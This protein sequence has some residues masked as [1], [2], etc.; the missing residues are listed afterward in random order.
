[1]DKM[2][3]PEK[4]NQTLDNVENFILN[5]L[6][7]QHDSGNDLAMKFEELMEY[8][9]TVLPPL[10]DQ[11]IEDLVAQSLIRCSD[12]ENYFITTIGIDKLEQRNRDAIPL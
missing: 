10:L 1:M 7:V 11:A 8:V 4:D 2:S 5:R 12:S 9:G 6:L 3:N